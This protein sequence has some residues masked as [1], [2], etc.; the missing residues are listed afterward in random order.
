MAETRPLNLRLWEG[1]WRSVPIHCI[2]GLTKSVRLSEKRGVITPSHASVPNAGASWVERVSSELVLCREGTSP[3]KG[4]HFSVNGLGIRSSPIDLWD[5]RTQGEK[6][7][8][9]TNHLANL[10]I[11]DYLLGFRVSERNCDA[12]GG[13]STLKYR[14][15][16][17]LFGSLCHNKGQQNG[18]SSS[19][20]SRTIALFPVRF[21]R[22]RFSAVARFPSPPSPRLAHPL[23]APYN[24]VFHAHGNSPYEADQLRAS[25]AR[26]KDPDRTP[27]GKKKRLIN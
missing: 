26:T 27:M 24:Q 17:P 14:S 4:N 15:L 6:K 3:E 13:A 11:G 25:P 22:C 19:R 20:N 9:R 2:P 12:L 16:R 18:N 8:N 21:S 1:T 10:S 5:D 23:P 7:R